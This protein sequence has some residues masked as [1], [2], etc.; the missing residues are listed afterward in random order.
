MSPMG[1]SVMV[2]RVGRQVLKVNDFPTFSGILQS[3]L[4]KRMGVILEPA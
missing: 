1:S 4:L 3:I 2:S